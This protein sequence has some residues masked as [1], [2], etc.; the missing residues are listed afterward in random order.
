LLSGF[1]S[2]HAIIVLVIE[3]PKGLIEAM[4]NG[5]KWAARYNEV[6]G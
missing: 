4:Q 5:M 6:R 3:A 2:S 1:R